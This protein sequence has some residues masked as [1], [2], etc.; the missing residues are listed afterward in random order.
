MTTPVVYKGFLTGILKLWGTQNQGF[1]NQVPTLEG[2]RAS[3][4]APTVSC[5][6]RGRDLRRWPGVR[7]VVGADYPFDL[8]VCLR[9]LAL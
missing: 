8:E 5:Q 3:M 4:N 6:K 9:Y 2:T 1:L 7:G